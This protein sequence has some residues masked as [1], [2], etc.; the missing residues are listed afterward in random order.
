MEKPSETYLLLC[1]ALNLANEILAKEHGE[2]EVTWVKQ[3]SGKRPQRDDLIEPQYNQQLGLKIGSEVE[4]MGMVDPKTIDGKHLKSPEVLAEEIARQ[5]RLHLT[6]K[7]VDEIIK[8]QNGYKLDTRLLKQHVITLDDDGFLNVNGLRLVAKVETG[9][10]PLRA[11]VFRSSSIGRWINEGDDI[12]VFDE[13]DLIRPD[14]KGM[15]IQL[16]KIHRIA[17]DQLV[18]QHREEGAKYSGLYYGVERDILTDRQIESLT[19]ISQEFPE[20]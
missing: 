15:L 3:L 8:F 1:G 18:E 17:V 11:Q 14:R 7:K 4:E 13:F 6:A 16:S 12:R 2:I 5:V 20:P 19:K 10:W 9:F